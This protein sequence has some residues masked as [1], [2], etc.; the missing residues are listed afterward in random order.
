MIRKNA[1]KYLIAI[2]LVA[3]I[4]Q[5]NAADRKVSPGESIQAAIDYVNS[6]GGGTVY[7]ERGIHIV[8]STIKMKSNVTI[9]G[10]GKYNTTVRNT[11]NFDVISQF[12]YGQNSMT[13]L[14]FTI[15]GKNNE[16]CFGIKIES[17]GA[18]HHNFLARN[19]DIRNCGM[20]MHVKGIY[21]VVLQ[22]CDFTCNGAPGKEYYFH[23]FYARRC[24]T[25]VRI[26]NCKMNYSTTANGM[27]FSYCTNVV[28]SNCEASGNYFRGIRAADTK[29]F[30]V[31]NCVITNNGA[32]GIIA[33]SEVAA[34]TDIQ[35]NNNCVSNNGNKGIYAVDGAT[36]SCV[37]NNSFGN[38][39]ANYDLPG[40][41]SQSGNISN[42]D[43][44]CSSI[45]STIIKQPD[46]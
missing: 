1:F 30:K 8:T 22:N 27:N 13:F 24:S 38:T 18:Y 4:A 10:A 36:G 3:S 32:Y 15:I 25:E 29:G 20:G 19:V 16:G 7:L 26:E 44:S 31:V 12:E 11:G 6:N 40:T 14:D 2:F 17:L 39:N 9:Q 45:I 5:L 43:K 23:N 35:I 21:G 46:S 33:N 41:V 34:T 28:I 37:D 42:P